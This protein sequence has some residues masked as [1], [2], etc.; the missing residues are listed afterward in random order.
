MSITS[1]VMSLIFAGMCATTPY[2]AY[3]WPGVYR[4]DAPPI[5]AMVDRK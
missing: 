1:V 5:S 2:L 3:A 4:S